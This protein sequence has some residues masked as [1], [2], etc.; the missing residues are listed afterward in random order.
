M[1]SKILWLCAAGMA[2]TLARVGL[3]SLIARAAPS[4]LP[5]G[6]LVVNII[7]CFLFGLAFA[8]FEGY[9][10]HAQDYRIV[11]LAGFMG[12]FTTFSSYLFDT[13]RLLDTGRVALAFTNLVVQNAL[14]L[15]GLGA[16]M[17]LGRR[18]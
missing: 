13:L 8:L 9:L 14:G 15:A 1:I 7:G 2:G 3:S 12:A 5:L 16:G 6:T 11:V 10:S 4:H 17:L 18:S